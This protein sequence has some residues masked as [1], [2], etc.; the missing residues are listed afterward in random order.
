MKKEKMS[1][2]DLLF[3]L[4]KK[5]MTAKE[6]MKLSGMTKSAVYRFI[7]EVDTSLFTLTKTSHQKPKYKAYGYKPKKI[8]P[9]ILR[10]WVN[11]EPLR[12][13]AEIAEEEGINRNSLYSVMSQYG[14]KARRNEFEENRDKSLVSKI[15]RFLNK[16]G[17][18][19]S[20]MELSEIFN[21][22]HSQIRAL[23][24]A[25]PHPLA[26]TTYQKRDLRIEELLSDRKIT[27]AEL[28]DLFSLKENNMKQYLKARPIFFN[29]K[30]LI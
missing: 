1:R 28:P 19:K 13:P 10:E 3:H 21:R 23:L 29:H 11:K 5:P 25:R 4:I 8:T 6:M 15:H 17:E 22:P 24:N 20:M 7:S 9:E 27:V 30:N 16:S 12:T 14:I 18:P 2:M 26:L